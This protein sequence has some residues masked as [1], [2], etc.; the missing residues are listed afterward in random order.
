MAE[1]R[2]SASR[3]P[4]LRRGLIALSVTLL[5][6]TVLLA[7]YLMQL[8]RR[9]TSTFEGR[10]WSVP[11][12]VFAR[13]LEL[14]PGLELSTLTLIEELE[15]V[16]YVSR[17]EAVLPGEYALNDNGLSLYLRAFSYP[18]GPRPAQRLQIRIEGGR[19]SALTVPGEGPAV[20]LPLLRLDPPSIGSIYP[21][22]G[23]DRVVLAPEQV[24]DLLRAA[25]I[26]VEDQRF[27]AHH[28]FDLRGILR[29]AWTNLRHGGFE[30]GGS[31]LTQQLV[32]SYFLSNER[33]LSRK[34]QELAMAVVLET[35]FSKADLLNAYINE[36]YLGQAGQ[37]AVHGFGLGAQFYFNKPLDELELAEIAALVAIIRGPSYYNPYRFPKRVRQRRD[38]VLDK[39][40]SGGVIDDEALAEA[41][42]TPLSVVTGRRKGGT[43][44]PAFMD[45]VRQE[46]SLRYDERQLASDGLRVFTTLDPRL[47]DHLDPRNRRSPEG[48]RGSP[49]AREQTDE[50]PALEAA[51]VVSDTQTGELLAVAGGRRANF[52]G[53]NRALKAQASDRLTDQARDLPDR[54]G[55]GR[56]ARDPDR[57]PPA[58]IAGS[59]RQS[60]DAAELRRNQ[61]RHRVSL[62]RALAQ[63]L[64]L[65]TVQLGLDLGVERIRD[66]IKA[67]TG[68]ETANP[69][70]SLLLGAE[71][72]TPLAVTE[73][74][75]LLSPAVASRC[76]RAAW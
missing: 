20:E 55:A 4:W 35:R 52:D 45:I 69:Y 37:R 11:A 32:K 53:Y 5:I 43:Y 29:A 73:L 40:H 41:V 14:Y 67:L 33:T 6:G 47:Q 19:L 46:L 2:R 27:E 49:Y 44:Y 28:G 10:R 12:V 48:P 8:D 61:S 18:E 65:A 38:L 63:S 64:N 54:A 24:P 59:R 34:L 1:Q 13:P 74:Y 60:L 7:G 68:H 36:I 22:H 66:R 9:I 23:E 17:P 51:A 15:R 57:R 70:P 42:A 56:D 76:D 50:P 39:L 26:A 30:Q 3:W 16:G 72:L 58:R 25:L 31:T 71:E 21:S 75:T 62:G